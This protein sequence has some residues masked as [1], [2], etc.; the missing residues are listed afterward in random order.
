MDIQNA[1]YPDE[2]E[3]IDQPTPVQFAKI[4]AE[5]FPVQIRPKNPLKLTPQK[6]RETVG[7]MVCNVAETPLGNADSPFHDTLFVKPHIE[8]MTVNELLGILE[9]DCEP[10]IVRYM[11]SQDG[12][13]PKEFGPL[14]SRVPLKIDWAQEVL[15]EPEA[16]NLWIG[17]S[18]TTSRLHND[19]YENLFLQVAGEKTI[20]L[21]PPGDAYGLDERFLIDATYK[22]LSDGKFEISID[23][24]DTIVAADISKTELESINK[25]AG[26]KNGSP[27]VLF[28]TVDPSNPETHNGIFRAHCKLYRVVLGAGDML[29]IPAL[30]YHQ[31]EISGDPRDVS[32]SVNYWHPASPTGPL[33][34]KWDFVRT[35][36]LVLR[37]YHDD[38]F[39]D[40]D[41]DL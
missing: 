17:N 19:N 2:I 36:S 32:I 14:G 20:Y 26:H 24:T 31:V 18:Q 8:K 7:G 29:Y 1:S 33:W 4:M 30:W 27:R 25:N 21:I 23:G 39:F 10:G 3:V 41:D 28:P 35:T 38:S 6:L 16:V 40:E 5:N 34:T 37:G 15:G 22:K 12:N 9:S 11:Q 13:L